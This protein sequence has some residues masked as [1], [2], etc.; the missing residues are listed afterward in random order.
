MIHRLKRQKKLNNNTLRHLL[1]PA[2]EHLDLDNTYVTEGTLKVIWSS[3]PHL[4]VLS[5]KDCGYL[6]TDNIM[7]QML[8]VNTLVHFFPL[9]FKII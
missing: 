8:K 5:L 7:E 4:R 9:L 2:L 3:C 1:V 6:I